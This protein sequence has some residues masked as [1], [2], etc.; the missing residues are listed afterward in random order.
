MRDLIGDLNSRVVGVARQ[1]TLLEVKPNTERV[2][3]I[4]V[5]PDRGLAGSLSSNVL[6]RVGRFIIEQQE[7]GRAVDTYAYGKK[8]RDFLARSG[9]NLKAEAIRLGDT[10]KLDQIL[11]VATAALSR[12]QSG[13]YSEVYLIYSE[14]I[15]TLVQRPQL[16]KLIP[17]DAPVE[18]GSSQLDFTYEPD[19]AELLAELL[20]RYVETQI[21]Q[22]I[23]ESIASFYSAQMVAMRNATK[24]A[25]DLARELTL[26]FNKARQAAITKEVSEISSG[27]AALSDG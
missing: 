26:S 21:Y 13:E 11:G 24:S 17:V 3:L 9:Q 1:G 2:A 27:A 7:L 12:V 4:V 6:R 18:S 14:F 15:N 5:T 10:P 8:G 16:K 22:A 20:P 23:L 19:Q 25:K